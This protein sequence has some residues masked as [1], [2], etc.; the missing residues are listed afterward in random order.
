MRVAAQLIHAFTG[1]EIWAER[2]DRELEDI[3]K[4]QD[5]VVRTIVITLESRLGMVMA[6][7]AGK[8]DSPNLA[9]YECLLLARKHLHLHN[10][11]QARPLVER[12]L[13]IDPN[14]ANAH[15]MLARTCF[16]KYLEN[17]SADTL[18]KMHLA[19]LKAV[20]LDEADSRGHAI[21]GMYFIC[22]KQFDLARQQLEWAIRLNPA[23]TF[24][25][26]TQAEMQLR[27]GDAAKALE[28]MDQLFLRD[29]NPHP[30]HWDIRATALLML[31]RFEE[32]ISAM[33]RVPQLYWYIHGTLAICHA[34]LGRANEAKAEIDKLLLLRPGMTIH[35]YL[36]L[37][38]FQRQEDLNY[39]AE[40][41]RIAGLPE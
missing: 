41:L 36:Q 32:A 13:E 22:E 3:F 25:L 5:E 33:S 29:P 40:G 7:D 39:L 16:I 21:L 10:A 20:A 2:Y 11:D 34:R 37:E 12:A 31:G 35:N 4:V 19:A 18:E 1:Q 28:T 15:A 26:G 24:A 6:N 30:G 38:E 17:S 27:T 9:A 8:R 23:D 14:Y